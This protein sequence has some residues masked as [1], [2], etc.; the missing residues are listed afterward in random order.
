MV[1]ER[2]LAEEQF[3]FKN[4]LFGNAL[5]PCQNAFKKVHHKKDFLMT[6]AISQSCTQIVAANNLARSACLRT[7]TQPCFRQEPFYMKIPTFFFA[8]TIES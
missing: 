3:H 2:L 1:S 5:F 8:R 6:K 4:H 7:A